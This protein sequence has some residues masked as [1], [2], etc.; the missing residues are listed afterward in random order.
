[1]RLILSYKGEGE[2]IRRSPH[3]ATGLQ[4][5]CG[6]NTPGTESLAIGPTAR[7]CNLSDYALNGRYMTL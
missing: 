7:P 4:G 5:L 1:M 3:K 6:L 2:Y